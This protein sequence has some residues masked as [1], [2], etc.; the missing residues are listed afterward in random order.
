MTAQ[1]RLRLGFGVSGPLGQNWFSEAK[2]RR[3]IAAAIEGGI[4]HFDTGPFYFNAERR[5]GA[6]LAALGSPDA[7]VSTKTGTRREGARLIKDFSERA[8]RADVEESR[9]RL[10]RDR[11]DLL[12]LHGPTVEEIEQ[13]LPLLEALKRE[14][15]LAAIG[16]CGEGAPLAHAVERGFDAIMGVYNLI[17]RRHESVFAEAKKRGVLT[18][19]VAPLAQ[20]L[21]DPKFFAPASLSDFWRIARAAFRGRYKRRDI[22]TAR[23]AL[24]AV[25]DLDPPVAALAFALAN[26]DI[27]IVM[28]TTTKSGH[29][30]RSIAAARTPLDPA[31]YAALKG[32]SL[33][34]P[35]GGS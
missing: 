7:F 31:V 28:T 4:A 8:I 15:S 1:S 6:G 13:T 9:R 5:L 22:E 32:L 14:G 19:A 21:F 27:D 35:G 33:D 18:V 10:G 16:V 34:R 12:Y 2:T 24:A 3:L 26:I 25:P 29:L 30:E 20:G 17:D 11:L 23:A